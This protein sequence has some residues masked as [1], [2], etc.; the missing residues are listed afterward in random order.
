MRLLRKVPQRPQRGLISTWLNRWATCSH[1]LQGL[2]EINHS[3]F[4]LVC[5][6]E[7]AVLCCKNLF[8]VV[9]LKLEGM[10]RI[11]DEMLERL[12]EYCELLEQVSVPSLVDWLIDWLILQSFGRLIDW[13]IDWLFGWLI[14]WLIRL[15]GWLCLRN[16]LFLQ[17][18]TS[19]STTLNQNLPKTFEAVQEMHE[20]Y[21]RIDQIEV[22]R[23][24]CCLFL[25]QRTNKLL[26]VFSFV[27]RAL[28]WRKLHIFF[29]WVAIWFFCM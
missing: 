7:H 11:S 16:L 8:F 3:I 29:S 25:E 19:T 4:L 17:L 26:L 6:D 13:L 2:S 24:L 14:G 10:E 15:I 18:R 9:F 27:A 28:L 12:A 23:P 1:S 5:L 21:R 20:V 22:R